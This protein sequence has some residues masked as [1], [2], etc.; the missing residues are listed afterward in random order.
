MSKHCLLDECPPGAVPIVPIEQSGFEAWIEAQDATVQQWV[1]DCGFHARP[2]TLCR[3]PDARRR[4][5]S[6]LAGI[7]A[8]EDL[9]ACAFLPEALASGRYHL[10]AGDPGFA[11]RAALAWGLASYRFERY[12]RDRAEAPQLAVEGIDLA[13]IRTTL[14]AVRLV[15]DLI[16]TPAEDL[17]PDQ[18]E[19]AMAKLAQGFGAQ[20]TAVTGQALLEKNFPAIHA[21]GRASASAPRL[22]D[23][24][25]GEPA[26]PRL[27][28]AGKGVCFDSGGLDLKPARSMRLM[29]K[30]MGGAAHAM[31]LAHMI[32]AAELKVHLRVLVP[33]VEN[34]IAGNALRPGDIISSRAGK[35]IE[36]ENTDAEGRLVLCDALTEAASGAPDLLIDFATLTGAARVA[37]GTEVPVFFTNDDALPGD[38][39]EA[40]QDQQDPLWRLPLHRPYRRMLKSELA[41]LRNCTSD[42]YA[43]AIT[44]AL[45]LDE[46]VPGEIPWLHIDL[47]GW[48]LRA[49]PGRPVGGEA[50]GLRAVFGMLQRRYG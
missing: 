45:F 22:L 48:N 3:I 24:R 47:M 1:R 41:D 5:A 33:A 26:Y 46:F 30:D 29:K 31:G 8:S 16:N 23:L 34:A 21:V 49:Q 12:K 18:L 14:D 50:M 36:I 28:L 9:W 39:D 4:V 43:G 38:L 19:Q 27:T 44:A 10:P 17:L 15:R 32:M 37:L 20:L 40:A 11:R 6:V 2:G 25:W 13:P 42:S 7:G 35:T